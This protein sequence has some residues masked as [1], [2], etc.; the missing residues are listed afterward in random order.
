M[1]LSLSLPFYSSGGNSQSIFPNFP[2]DAVG[3][4]LGS[5]SATGANTNLVAQAWQQVFASVFFCYIICSCP[6]DAVV[7][8]D[9]SLSLLRRGTR[10]PRL[11]L[12]GLV[13]LD[14]AFWMPTL[15]TGNGPRSIMM[16]V[17]I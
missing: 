17:L 4:T 14:Q 6:M 13:Q 12:Q 10:S 11:S 7:F 2:A 15:F 1:Y 3:A 9:P 5:L 8:G 16:M